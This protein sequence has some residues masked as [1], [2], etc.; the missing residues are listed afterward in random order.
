VSQAEP[1]ILEPSIDVLTYLIPRS[2][3]LKDWNW[4]S[5]NAGIKH[6][7]QDADKQEA[8]AGAEARATGN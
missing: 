5:S 4:A 1:E 7:G 8:P 2:P 6:E 3:H